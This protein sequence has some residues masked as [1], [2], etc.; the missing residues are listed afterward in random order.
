MSSTAYLPS[1]QSDSPTMVSRPLSNWPDIPIEQEVKKSDS[2][3]FSDRPQQQV[4]HVKSIGPTECAILLGLSLSEAQAAQENE[5]IPS[6]ALPATKSGSATRLVV[7][8]RLP[9]CS[10]GRTPAPHS[11]VQARSSQFF[12]SVEKSGCSPGSLTY[13]N[14][15]RTAR[16]SRCAL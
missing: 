9:F 15:L 2:R 12:S 13:T 4:R 14:S 1:C 3:L 7:D 8:N 10:V 5:T 16:I 11:S 6:F